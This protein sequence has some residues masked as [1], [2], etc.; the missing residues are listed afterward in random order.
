MKKTHLPFRLLS[1]WLAL[2]LP[3][4]FA[5]PAG[6]ATGGLA[7]V[8]ILADGLTPEVRPHAG[9]GYMEQVLQS[10]VA[11]ATY[12][13]QGSTCQTNSSGKLPLEEPWIHATGSIVEVGDN[14]ATWDSTPQAL[15]LSGR[16][17]TPTSVAAVHEMVGEKSDGMP[18]G[19]NPM[20][21]YPEESWTTWNVCGFSP[22]ILDPNAP[23]NLEELQAADPKEVAQL[24]KFDGRNYGIITPVRDQGSS[25]LCWAYASV[26]ASE[27]S[28]LREG[29]GAALNTHG[30][31][32]T[33]LG[34][35]RF[36][37]GP[38]LLGNTAGEE[39]PTAD[40]LQASGSPGYSSTLF[41]QWWGPVQDGTPM[42][43]TPSVIEEH[44]GYRMEHAIELDGQRLSSNPAAR[45]RMKEAIAQYG[46]VT[47]SYNWIHEVP[48]DNPSRGGFGNPHA[49]TIIGWD[50]TIPASLFSGGASQDGGW[51][52][53]NSYS[54]LPYFYLSYD[55]N[56]SYV[57]AFDYATKEEYDFNYFYDSSVDDFGMA[58]S[59]NY[60]CAANV[61]QGL[62]GS[63]SQT[64]YVKAVQVGF[65]GSGATCDVKVYTNL[66]DQQ[67]MSDL[68][69]VDPTL[70]TL[71]ASGSATFDRPGYHTVPLEQLAEVAP[72]S[73]FSI[74]VQISGSSPYLRVIRAADCK[75]YV[76][77]KYG[78]WQ[79]SGLNVPRLKA[80]TV[81]ENTSTGLTP[82]ETPHASIDDTAEA[83]TG[84][85]PEATYLVNSAA[86]TADGNGSLA[87]QPEWFGS[88]VSIVKQ[89]DGTA[90]GNSVAQTL[91]IPNRPAAPAGVE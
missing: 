68:A 60:T 71:A 87:L 15:A 61:F 26:N 12:P 30:L 62:K 76:L 39:D 9:V 72:G 78:A 64:E 91:K 77:S 2:T 37:R 23:Q 16:S 57:F 41:S 75:S 85:M 24:S 59:L 65:Y 55:N 14:I 49:C 33:Q 27:A 29:I 3:W 74:V 31:S 46:A 32:H 35:I 86:L 45:T 79:K 36:N 13:I 83:L 50:D 11:E 25:N 38:D 8:N 73:Y 44:S 6:A 89:G 18:S 5:A 69:N 28:I 54:S 70:G 1:L 88:T 52:V 43:N 17:D 34:Y 66:Q 22:A 21:Q 63:D 53:K 56:S 7:R 51:L 40:W 20:M 67:D 80:Y 47:F 84:L 42:V 10:L 4:G 81:L 19:T 82:E 48:Y 90:T 58:A